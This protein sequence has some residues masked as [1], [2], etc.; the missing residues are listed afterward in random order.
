M[1]CCL[2]LPRSWVRL[3][4][5]LVPQHRRPCSVTHSCCAVLL[6]WTCR[7]MRSCLSLKTP[8]HTLPTTR[9]MTALAGLT[10]AGGQAKSIPPHAE[11]QRPTAPRLWDATVAQPPEYRQD[12]ALVRLR[13]R[14]EAHAGSRVCFFVLRNGRNA[15]AASVCGCRECNTQFA[16]PAA[17]NGFRC[18]VRVLNALRHF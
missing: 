4:G 13:G 10:T 14:T 9:H 12:A 17:D 18:W 3:L 1:P 11:L 15:A 6:T 5:C 7:P 8:T 2:V 16:L